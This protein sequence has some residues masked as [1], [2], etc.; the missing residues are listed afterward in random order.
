MFAK[1]LQLEVDRISVSVSVT[2]TAPKLTI[3]D[4]RRG[5]DFGRKSFN[6]FGYGFGNGRNFR[7]VSAI[8]IL[9]NSSD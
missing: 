8:F 4:Y 5:F 9:W 7:L 6:S 2:V 3:N 1:G